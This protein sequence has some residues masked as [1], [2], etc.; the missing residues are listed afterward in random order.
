MSVTVT[1]TLGVLGRK[2][3]HAHARTQLATRTSDWGHFEG[4]AVAFGVLDLAANRMMVGIPNSPARFPPR[5]EWGGNL[6]T[7]GANVL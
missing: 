4:P 3:D 2:W 1:L 7:K 5:A 6:S